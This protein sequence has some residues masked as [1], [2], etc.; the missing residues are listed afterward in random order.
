MP[1]QMNHFAWTSEPTVIQVH[2]AG[3]FEFIYAN[4]AEDPR[5][6]Q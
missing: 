5:K 2:G 3:P 1:A 6:V 4:P